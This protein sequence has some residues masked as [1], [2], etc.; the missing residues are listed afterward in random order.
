MMLLMMMMLMMMRMPTTTTKLCKVTP[1]SAD[2]FLLFGDAIVSTG[3]SA[4]D[5]ANGLANL[6]HCHWL[7]TAQRPDRKVNWCVQEVF[8][9]T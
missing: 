8:C 3:G 6:K 7:R 9:I 5:A 1:L 4:N 2:D